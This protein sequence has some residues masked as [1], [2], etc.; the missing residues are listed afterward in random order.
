MLIF[1]GWKGVK[2]SISFLGGR[3]FVEEKWIRESV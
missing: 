1:Y 3:G 2:C